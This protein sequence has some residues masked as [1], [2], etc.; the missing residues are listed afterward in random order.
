MLYVKRIIIFITMGFVIVSCSA[1]GSLNG[2]A[3]E[4]YDFHIESK[5]D[6]SGTMYNSVTLNISQSLNI[7]SIKRSKKGQFLENSEVT[8]S[9][10]GGAGTLT[11]SPD[12]KSAIF[13]AL[14]NGTSTVRVTVDKKTAELSIIVSTDPNAFL[15]TGVTG[16]SDTDLDSNLKDGV[17]PTINWNDTDY[18][19]SYDVAIYE[20]DGSTIACATENVAI[21]S[22]SH[23]F[24]GCSLTAGQVYKVSVI[25]KGS[26]NASDVLSTNNLYEFIVAPSI[27]I[28]DVTVS[29]ADGTAD[30]V[31]SLNNVSEYDIN[32]DWGT[33]DSSAIST[34]DAIKDFDAVSA[35]TATIVAGQASVTLS[36]SLNDDA[37]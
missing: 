18:E 21:D 13:N 5:S 30:F 9:S 6:G 20:D 17:A 24:S 36:V 3:P 10:Q 33:V 28:A 32:F 8:W 35:A 22:T 16:G 19:D 31:V 15:I 1:A 26:G 2:I 11:I 12:G 14:S 29:E 25:A 37:F 4:L 34:P 7:F 27:S 23:A